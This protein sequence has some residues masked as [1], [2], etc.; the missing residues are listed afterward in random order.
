MNQETVSNNIK[1]SVDSDSLGSKSAE[2][3]VGLMTGI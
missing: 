2:R 3:E 1:S